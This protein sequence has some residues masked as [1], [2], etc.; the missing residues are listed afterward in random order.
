[1]SKVHLFK[2]KE[3]WVNSMDILIIGNIEGMSG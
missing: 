1:M 3:Y 2:S